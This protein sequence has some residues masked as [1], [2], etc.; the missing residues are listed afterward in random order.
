M[1]EELA[2]A[3]MVN[4]KVAERTIEHRMAWNQ[5]AQIERLERALSAARGKLATLKL[6]AKVY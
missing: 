1:Y 6:S 5:I 4:L 2:N 3:Q